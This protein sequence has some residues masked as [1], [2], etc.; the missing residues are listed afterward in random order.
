MDEPKKKFDKERSELLNQL[1]GSLSCVIS[2]ALNP[3]ESTFIL[4]T[5]TN[6]GNDQLLPGLVS[7]IDKERAVSL[8]TK[9][10]SDLEN[11]KGY[12]ERKGY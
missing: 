5:A 6:I 11:D 9:V 8:L 10:L 3:F 2:S 12:D 1:L 4:V 7:P